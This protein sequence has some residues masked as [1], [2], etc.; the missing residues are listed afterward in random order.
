MLLV[1]PKGQNQ[2]ANCS[3]TKI[4]LTST[5]NSTKTPP[6]I[7]WIF[8]QDFKLMHLLPPEFH[9]LPPKFIFLTPKNEVLTPKI[10]PPKFIEKQKYIYKRHVI[11]S[12]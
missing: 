8:L 5:K 2:G 1:D 11:K 3:G 6:K 4:S 10:L 9:L 12:Q 7:F